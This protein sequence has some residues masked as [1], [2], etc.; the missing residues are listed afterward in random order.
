KDGFDGRPAGP[1]LERRP[2][3]AVLASR[4]RHDACRRGRPSA[5]RAHGAA[6]IRLTARTGPW[7]ARAQRSSLPSKQ[8]MQ[9][10]SDPVGPGDLVLCV[11]VAPNHATGRPV[12]LVAGET[13]RVVTVMEF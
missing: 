4:R 5:L 13:Y 8:G 2:A 6:N 1:H 3:G 12:P 10:M 11:N 7:P 9:A